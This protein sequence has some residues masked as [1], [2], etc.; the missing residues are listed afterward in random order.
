[1]D[2][3]TVPEGYEAVRFQ[4][5]YIGNGDSDDDFEVVIAVPE[6][7]SLPP[8]NLIHGTGIHF[9]DDLL[10]LPA[11]TLEMEG[12]QWVPLD[13]SFMQAERAS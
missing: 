5:K 1:M 11:S 8:I 13:L 6:G 4:S 9:W 2:T 12:T 10:R 3:L 7:T